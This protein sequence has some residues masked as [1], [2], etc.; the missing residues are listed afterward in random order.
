[1]N[2]LRFEKALE[3]LNNTYNL[4]IINDILLARDDMVILYAD[5]TDTY[6]VNL[7]VVAGSLTTIGFDDADQIALETIFSAFDF[8][9]K[10]GEINGKKEYYKNIYAQIH[11][12]GEPKD[13][14]FPIIIK[15][16]R[17]WLRF[18]IIPAKRNQHVSIFS[19]TD[20]TTLHTQE[21]E[22]FGKTHIDSLTKLLNNYAFDHHYGRYY[23]M[24]GFHVMY[25]DLDDFK[26]INDTYGHSVGNLYLQAVAN[27]LK[28]LEKEFIR[29]YRIGGDEFIG[30]LIGSESEIKELASKIIDK[31][32]QISIL[33][34]DCTLT[35]SMGVMRANQ[36][37]DLAR[38][39]DK[40]MYSVKK[41]GKNNFL[42]QIE[43]SV[44]L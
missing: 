17:K 32:K 43:D 20:V 9:N 38:K 42:Y 13:V 8:N 15:G 37:N 29:F 12:F 31:V 34:I 26:N 7:V 19:I 44:S 41:M 2:K 24:P 23:K 16:I 27:I 11:D 36:S 28:G 18:N 14:S 33:D 4:D 1:M 5:T 6:D 22:T 30:L 39:A 35:L 3:T 25:I 40:L 21:E 10:Y